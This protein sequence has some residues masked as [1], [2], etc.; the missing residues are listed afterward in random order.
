[1]VI[2]GRATFSAA[3][4]RLP[5]VSLSLS[6]GIDQVFTSQTANNQSDSSAERLMDL[7]LLSRQDCVLTSTQ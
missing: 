4:I 2:R 7:Y 3:F 1:M 5:A 6:G